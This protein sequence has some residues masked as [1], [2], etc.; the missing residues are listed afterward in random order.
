MDQ[1]LHGGSHDPLD[2]PKGHFQ[3]AHQ[4]HGLQS[5]ES[6]PT[7]VGMDRAKRSGMARG[8]GLEHRYRLRAPNLADN[9][10]VRSHSQTG[11]D[12]IVHG[13]LSPALH[14]GIPG[15]HSY[16]IIHVKKLQFRRIFDRDDPLR[17]SDI[18]CQRI[19][20]GRLAGIG[21]PAYKNVESGF[22]QGSQNRSQRCRKFPESDQAVNTHSSL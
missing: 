14:I 3:S 5:P 22:H 9:D 19:Q 12:Q 6:I 1:D 20:Q 13:N 2:C 11:L 4:Y 21:C 17:C 7:G 16:Q 18:L 8:Q 15:L 10:P